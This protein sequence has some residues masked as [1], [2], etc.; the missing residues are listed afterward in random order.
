M[1]LEIR[2][3]PYTYIT[4]T[5]RTHIRIYDRQLKLLLNYTLSKA[6]IDY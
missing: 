6:M 1:S 4:Y 3:Y 5:Y 2:Y